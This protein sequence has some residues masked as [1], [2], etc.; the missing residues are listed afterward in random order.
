MQEPNLKS[1]IYQKK[2][3]RFERILEMKM[4][5]CEEKVIKEAK[6]RVTNWIN[7]LDDVI[8]KGFHTQGIWDTEEFETTEVGLE[9]FDCKKCFR[10]YLGFVN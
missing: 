10:E 1:H 7:S 6:S 4:K 8:N 9:S 2:C 3:Y 5:F